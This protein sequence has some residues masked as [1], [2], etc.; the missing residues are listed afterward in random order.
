[1]DL[2]GITE[3]TTLGYALADRTPYENIVR[4]KAGEVVQIDEKTKTR[5][6]YWRWDDIKRSSLGEPE[7]LKDVYQTFST[8]VTSR[9]RDDTQTIAMLSGG[10]DSRSVV[11]AL[12]AKKAHVYTFNFSNRGTQ[13]EVFSSRFASSIGT[14]HQ[15]RAQP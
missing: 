1:M 6:H 11:T 9:L 2:R 3:M 14:L 4:L 15:G 5:T 12:C 10:M 7:L 13:D 8:G